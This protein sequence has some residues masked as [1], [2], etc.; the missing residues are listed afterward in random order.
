MNKLATLKLRT[1]FIKGHHKEQKDKPQTGKKI[2][3]E[4]N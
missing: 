1:L 2:C 3:I 4:Y